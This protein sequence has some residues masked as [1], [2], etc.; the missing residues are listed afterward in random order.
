MASTIS[1]RVATKIESKNESATSIMNVTR[2]QSRRGSSGL[3][4]SLM[5]QKRNNSDAAAQARRA[6]FHNMKPTPGFFGKI[7]HNFTLGPT[8]SK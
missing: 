8:P 6:S 4:S 1:T 5:D 2:Q 3:F 7:W